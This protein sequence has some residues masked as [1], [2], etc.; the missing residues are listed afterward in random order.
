MN[1]FY[2]NYKQE[3][4]RN[5][6]TIIFHLVTHKIVH[7]IKTLDIKEEYMT[8]TEKRDGIIEN[9]FVQN[10]IRKYEKQLLLV[11]YQFWYLEFST[12]YSDQMETESSKRL[13]PANSC[14]QRSD[15]RGNFKGDFRSNTT[16]YFDAPTS[17]L[18]LHFYRQ[19]FLAYF[20]YRLYIF[21]GTI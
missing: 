6:T 19:I 1:A 20:N 7:K 21:E 8:N 5:I 17:T 10:K 16:R 12:I 4:E 15:F 9:N 18:L 13:P 14:W 2:R 3:R 11:L